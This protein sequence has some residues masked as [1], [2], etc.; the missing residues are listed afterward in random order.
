MSETILTAPPTF[1]ANADAIARQ[2]QLDAEAEARNAKMDLG[3]KLSA[4]YYNGFTGSLGATLFEQ[5]FDR[6]PTYQLTQPEFDRLSDG[7]PPHFRTGFASAVSQKH[8]EYLR[9][10]YLD[11]AKQEQVLS[12]AGTLGKAIT[13]GETLTNPFMLAA[14]MLTGGAGMAAN[15]GRAGLAVRSGLVAGGTFATLEGVRS[16]SD[17]RVTNRQI[18]TAGLTGFG[19]GLGG[20]LAGQTFVK[21]AVG[22]GGGGAAGSIAADLGARVAGEDVSN[23]ELLV[24]AGTQLAFGGL[25]AGL[26]SITRYAQARDAV[27]RRMVKDA[28]WEAIKKQAKD[29][30]FDP[31]AI[32]TKEEQLYFKDQIDQTARTAEIEAVNKPVIDEVLADMADGP[33]P[34]PDKA[35]VSFAE[36]RFTEVPPGED[37]PAVPEIEL[38]PKQ[39]GDFDVSSVRDMP[40]S[41]LGAQLMVPGTDTVMLTGRFSMGSH[42]GQSP[43]G[44]VRDVGAMVLTDLIPRKGR[45]VVLDAPQWAEG[46][47]QGIVSRFFSENDATYARHI[48][49]AR[50]SGVEPVPRDQFMEEVGRAVRRPRG[51]YTDNAEVNNA[52]DRLRALFAENHSLAARHGVKGFDRFDQSDTY[53]TRMGSRNKID[54]AYARFDEDTVLDVVRNAVIKGYNKIGGFRL[55]KSD[56]ITADELATII[57]KNWLKKVGTKNTGDAVAAIELSDPV[58]I[59]AMLR[60]QVGGQ[61]SE[62]QILAISEKLGRDPEKRGVMSQARRRTALDETHS[63]D[64]VDLAGNETTLGI[65]DLLENN[66]EAIASV[67]TRR[68]LGQA[69][70]S[71]VYRNASQITG[72]KIET[73]GDLLKALR[74]EAEA[75][76]GYSERAI[77]RDLSKIE[78]GL[79]LAQ[80]VPLT[81][82]T[83]TVRTMRAIRNLN[84]IRLMSNATT[85]IRNSF[86][87]VG[88]MAEVGPALVTKYMP[89]VASM[90]KRLEN[91]QLKDQSLREMA[92]FTGLGESYSAKRVLPGFA[93]EMART[94]KVEE[95][96]SKGTRLASNVSLTAPGQTAIERVAGLSVL[97][98][99]ADIA[100]SGKYIEVD[101]DGV[102]TKVWSGKKL[103]TQRRLGL[104]IQDE[105]M[106]ERIAVQLRKAPRDELGNVQLDFST[107]DDVGAGSAF[108]NA[109]QLQTSRLV[110]QNNPAAYA[111]W[112]TTEMGKVIAQLRTFIFGA[113]EGKL[114]YNV[115]MADKAAFMQWGISSIG[116]AAGFAVVGYLRSLELPPD[117][118]LEW[119]KKYLSAEGLIK[120]G[121]SQAAYSSLLPSAVDTVAPMFGFDEVFS[122]ARTTGQRGT[123]LDNPTFDWARSAWRSKDAIFGPINPNYDFSQQNVRDLKGALW[124]PRVMGVDGII[125]YLTRDLPKQSKREERP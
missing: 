36:R 105:A 87:I 19:F 58:E 91:G 17:P 78:I 31:V 113:W 77:N 40:K 71:E 93:D 76:P 94:N 101:I 62:R 26:G 85:G 15:V 32:A 80:G 50:E 38:P 11:L 119:Q 81:E 107:W 118:R 117:K 51:E 125:N 122:F 20:H 53:F 83:A 70:V 112:M 84:Y 66:A 30:G 18:A 43:V 8:A 22:M 120:A 16:V 108:R 97:N 2:R 54:D 64:V 21:Q 103:S 100:S 24:N 89:D 35:P 4:A 56:G 73:T 67:Y 46:R 55:G 96:I 14:G 12:D 57:A 44:A 29:D 95:L 116:A 27:G 61:V 104:G 49:K 121:F 9:V 5:T 48:A 124:V 82:N 90:F 115:A 34:A 106:L 99:W 41:T 13:I 92:Y 6:D 47:T 68:V 65:E 69:A 110:Q 7:I 109:L 86:E 42:V 23:S 10:R 102:A 88:A 74:N 45:A 28:Q 1:E 72:K 33:A 111:R 59:A 25:T 3:D 60:E 79:K 52:A 63:Q 39:I 37:A 75:T 114:L 123:L 98:R